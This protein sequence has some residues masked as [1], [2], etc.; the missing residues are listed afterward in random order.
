MEGRR[1]ALGPGKAGH[2]SKEEAPADD[3]GV[4]KGRNGAM[5]PVERR[6][7]ARARPFWLELTARWHHVYEA[8]AGV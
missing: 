8:I 1:V 4:L 7:D 5:N 6:D 3:D 2:A